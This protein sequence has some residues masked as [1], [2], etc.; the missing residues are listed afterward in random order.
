MEF[1]KSQ[2]TPEAA[3]ALLATSPGNRIM[4]QSVVRLYARDMAAGNWQLTH[5]GL[6]LGKN[7]ILL[8]GHHRLHAVV[9]SK[10]SQ[11]FWVAKDESLTSPRDLELDTGYKRKKSYILGV[12]EKLVS[13]S[14]GA[15]IICTSVQ[16]SSNAEVQKWA[17][18]LLSPY[19]KLMSA[20]PSS[21]RIFSTV[22]CQLGAITQLLIGADEKFVLKQY[23]AFIN[24]EYENMSPNGQSFFKQITVENKKLNT[25]QLFVRAFRAFDPQKKDH[26]KLQVKDDAFAYQ[27]AKE[28]LILGCRPLLQ[29]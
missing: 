26:T 2:I 5:Q 20:A 29:K 19:S 6:L 15:I 28:A 7:G 13:V 22:N 18:F 4:S 25:S 11:W 23:K 3:K 9:A 12:S 16:L 27:E 17:D 21:R 14:Q 10:T 1:F 24:A 8:D